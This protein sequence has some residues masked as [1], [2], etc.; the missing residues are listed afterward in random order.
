MATKI[1]RGKFTA[2]TPLSDTLAREV[3]WWARW[4]PVRDE[5][6]AVFDEAGKLYLVRYT[7]HRTRWTRLYVHVLCQ[8][9]GGRDMHLHPWDWFV[10]IPL[11]RGYV[12]LRRHCSILVRGH[13]PRLRPRSV[14]HRVTGIAPGKP[15]VTLVFCFVRQ[16]AEHAWGFDVDDQLIPSTSYGN[17]GTKVHFRADTVPVLR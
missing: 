6:E 15:V 16:R 17:L 8:G 3:P 13:W 2:V 7:V 12:E 5:A 14:F 10:T 4:L 1:L 11:V 9:D